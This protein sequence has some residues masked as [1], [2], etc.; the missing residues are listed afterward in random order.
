MMLGPILSHLEE[1]LA[2]REDEARRTV[3][4]AVDAPRAFPGA[5]DK[6]ATLLQHVSA[7]AGDRQSYYVQGPAP[8]FTQAASSVSWHTA[9]ESGRPCLGDASV[10]YYPVPGSDELII[11]VPHLNSEPDAYRSMAKALN[12]FGHSV[13]RYVLP[14]HEGATTDRRHA[15]DQLVSASLGTTIAAV[16]QAVSEVNALAAHFQDRGYRRIRLVG[17]SVGCC[18]ATITAAVSGRFEGLCLFLMADDFASVVWRGRA[19]PHLQAELA[20]KITL[21]ELQ[22]AWDLL[23]P[24]RYADLL[25]AHRTPVLM[26]T[27]DRDT[28]MPLDLA[29]NIA[30]QFQRSGVALE[31]QRYA[32][33]HYTFGLPPFNLLAFRHLLGWLKT[34]SPSA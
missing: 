1:H 28:V 22:A 6:L 10:E 32:C 2:Q 31:W 19:T 24:Y 14:F 18:I 27:G 5:E 17:I 34:G 15:C 33:G 16:H 7:A 12:R 11:I 3:P 9:H 23:H 29:E 20:G 30:R 13:V 21:A 4:F 26:I 25:S 8:T